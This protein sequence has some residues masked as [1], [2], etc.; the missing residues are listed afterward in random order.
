MKIPETSISPTEPPETK[1]R[2]GYLTCKVA[3]VEGKKANDRS[4]KTVYAVLKSKTLYM[5]K[6]KKMA[7]ENLEYEEKPVKLVESE[8]EVANDYTKRKNVFRV[9]TDNNSEYLFQAEN[10]CLMKEWVHV[11]DKAATAI[12][13][14]ERKDLNK[15]RKLTSFRNRSPTGQSPASKSRKPSAETIP[16]YKD[17]DKDKKTWKGKVVNKLKNLGGGPVP[18]YP[19]GGSIS[20]PLELCPVCPLCQVGSPTCTTCVE[21]VPLELCPVCPLCQVGSPTC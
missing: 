20:V 17:K 9:K 7:L 5:Y 4:W 12:I 10:E 13:V 1:I 16:P 14:D 11:I 15:L 18:L 8:V 3:V 19:E 21:F 2:E 6:D